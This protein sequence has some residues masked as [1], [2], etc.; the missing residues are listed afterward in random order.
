[1]NSSVERTCRHRCLGQSVLLG[2]AMVLAVWGAAAVVESKSDAI[3]GPHPV[4]AAAIANAAC[5]TDVGH[6]F[7]E[8]DCRDARDT[9][10]AWVETQTTNGVETERSSTPFWAVPFGSKYLLVRSPK[11][12]AGKVGGTIGPLDHSVSGKFAE[13][14]RKLLVP[15]SM[16]VEDPRVSS[17]IIDALVVGAAAGIVFLFVRSFRRCLDPSRHPAIARLASDGDLR[18]ISKQF[19][20]ERRESDALLFRSRL[21]TRSFVFDERHLRFEMRRWRDLL[22]AYAKVTQHRVHH[23]PTGKTH[24][25]V[26]AFDDG[27][28]LE[29]KQRSAIFERDAEERVRGVLALV[30]KRAPWAVFGYDQRMQRNWRKERAAFREAVSKRRDEFEKG[31]AAPGA[32]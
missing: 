14:E 30:A 18:E 2:V 6:E 10:I 11:A 19:E 21:L 5:A 3:L 12:P 26:L 7:I 16:N 23:I 15:F 28:Q 4:E 32:G 24:A 13:H 31:A 20:R 27:T 25:L 9:G 22:W 1:M 8:I 17:W 29:I